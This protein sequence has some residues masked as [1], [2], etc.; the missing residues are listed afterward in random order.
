MAYCIKRMSDRINTVN[1]LSIDE[2]R[3]KFR[4]IVAVDANA[5]GGA[6][7]RGS[8][9]FNLPPMTSYGFSDEY[10]SCIIKCDS[11][12]ASPGETVAGGV[13]V[14]DAVWGIAGAGAAAD[15]LKCPTI[16]VRMNIGGS[17]AS[18]NLINPVAAGD[19]GGPGVGLSSIGG[20][21][22]LMPLQIVNSGNYAA[23]FPI[24]GESATWVSIGSSGFT[25][26][27]KCANPFGSNVRISLHSPCE[28]RSAYLVSQAGLAAGVDCG[29][30]YFQFS[31]TMVPNAN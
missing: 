21:R 3:L 4:C 18:S 14:A 24:T 27:I 30:Y 7:G 9:E 2:E 10:S 15:V 23:P 31:I 19:E 1:V 5:L 12:T 29:R 16:E 17:Q 13:L 20:F 8:Y 6:F 28:E 25:D 22:Q 26:A 11:F